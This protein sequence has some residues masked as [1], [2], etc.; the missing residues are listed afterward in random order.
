MA[1]CQS[2]WALSS[3][4]ELLSLI[5]VLPSYPVLPRLASFVLTKCFGLEQPGFVSVHLSYTPAKTHCVYP[6]STLQH[7]NHILSL[8]LH[9]QHRLT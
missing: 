5:V 1:D 8:P 9:M 3:P 6:Y 7:C 2:G 4:E